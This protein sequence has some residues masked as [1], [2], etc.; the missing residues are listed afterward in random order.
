MNSPA[1]PKFSW[2]DAWLLHAIGLAAAE[3][4]A[5]LKEIISMGDAVEKSVFS[6]EEI[7]SGLAKLESV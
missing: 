1:Q 2:S 6:F 7:S 3:H 5:T 4:P